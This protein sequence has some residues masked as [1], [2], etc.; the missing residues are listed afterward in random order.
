MDRQRGGQTDRQTDGWMD[1]LTDGQAD[2]WMDGQ[3][4]RQADRQP[5]RQLLGKRSPRK[6]K[7]HPETPLVF[8]LNFT[9]LFIYFFLTKTS[10]PYTAYRHERILQIPLFGGIWKGN[11]RE[12]GR[13]GPA[14]AGPRWE[15]PH[16]AAVGQR[17][18]PMRYSSD[19]ENRL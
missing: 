7:D 18:P 15:R 16:P 5:Y 8:L 1:G 4:D 11:I 6:G 12:R 14:A 17:R 9:G 19:G 3:T 2:R 13:V 10:K